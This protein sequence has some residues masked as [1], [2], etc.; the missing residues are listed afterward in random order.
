MLEIGFEKVLFSGYKIISYAVIEPRLS[1]RS[2][3]CLSIY[4]VMS[5]AK[6]LNIIL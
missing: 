5:Y 6:K 1:V 2:S 3:W 4:A